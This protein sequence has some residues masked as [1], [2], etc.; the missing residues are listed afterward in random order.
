MHAAS[1]SHTPIGYIEN[2]GPDFGTTTQFAGVILTQTAIALHTGAS[3]Q[4]RLMAQ[5]AVTI[6]S[7]TVVQPLP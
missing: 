2:H 4:G 3:V 1:Y 6:E 5:T 7:S